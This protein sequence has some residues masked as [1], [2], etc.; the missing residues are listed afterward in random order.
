MALSYGTLGAILIL[1]SQVQSSAMQMFRAG[2]TNNQ[3][4]FVRR[5]QPRNTSKHRWSSE[6][7]SRVSQRNVSP[8]L[9]GQSVRNGGAKR[10]AST[11]ALCASKL[12]RSHHDLVK[13]TVTGGRRKV[14]RAVSA[15]RAS[16]AGVAS[17]SHIEQ[18]QTS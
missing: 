18:S 1:Q 2:S 8:R 11:E 13:A 4:A 12:Q 3:N 6:Q 9:S 15:S 5:V 16:M 17:S 10:A 14:G 7:R